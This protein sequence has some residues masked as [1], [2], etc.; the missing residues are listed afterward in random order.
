[1]KLIST[2]YVIE[3]CSKGRSQRK[4]HIKAHIASRIL[5][6]VEKETPL[7]EKTSTSGSKSDEEERIIGLETSSTSSRELIDISVSPL[8]HTVVNH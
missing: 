2:W 4:W 8:L 3:S 6:R 5:S 7:R 1:M